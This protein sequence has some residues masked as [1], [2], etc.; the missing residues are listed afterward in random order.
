MSQPSDGVKQRMQQLLQDELMAAA[1]AKLKDPLQAARPC[2]RTEEQQSA[3]VATVNESVQIPD[4]GFARQVAVIAAQALKIPFDRF[5]AQE[6]MSRYGVDSIIVTEIMRHISDLLQTPIAPTVFF[7]ARHTQELAQ[8]LSQRYPAAVA[9]AALPDGLEHAAHEA[10]ET[11]SAVSPASPKDDPDPVGWTQ[12]FFQSWQTING[13][14]PAFSPA[15]TGGGTSVPVAI[16]GMAGQFAQSRDLEAFE[17]NLRQERDCISQVPLDRWDWREVFGDPRQGDYTRV[18]YGGFTPDID[19]FDAQ[20]FGISPREAR[21]MDPQH[22]RYMQCVWQAIESA[23]YAPGSLAGK[24]VGLFIGIN[25]QDYAHLIDREADIEAMHLTSLGHMFCPNRISFLLDLHGPSQVIDTACSSSLVALH[26]AVMSIRHEGCEMAIAGGA[27]LMI[28]SDMHVMYSKVGMICEDGRCKT[29]SDRANGYAR[30]DGVG[31]VVLKRLDLAQRDRDPVLAVI[32]GSAENH[33][34]ASSSL[35]APNPNAQAD[36]IVQAHEDAGVDPR[37]VGYIECHG[38]GTSLG[39]PIEASGLKMALHRLAQRQGLQALPAGQCAIGS[40]KSNIGHAETAAGIAGVIKTV[41]SLQNAYLYRTL[42]CDTLNPMLE[43]SGSPLRVLQ[44]AQVWDQPVIDGTSQPRCAGVS[45]FGAGGS[46]AHVVIQEYNRPRLRHDASMPE[47]MIFSA[48]DR[49]RL[50]TMIDQWRLFLNHTPEQQ[51]PTLSEMAYTM[52]VGRDAMPCR[53]AL[54]IR[55]VKELSQSL[56]AWMNGQALS[57]KAWE[58]NDKGAPCHV[59]STDLENWIN[60]GDWLSLGQAWVTGTAI[61]WNRVKRS[62]NVR[63]AVLPTYPFAPKRH[64]FKSVVPTQPLHPLLHQVRQNDGVWVFTSKFT[65]DAAFLADHRINGVC[66]LPAAAYLEMMRVAWMHRCQA[67]FPEQTG[68]AW[69]LTDVVWVSAMQVPENVPF[70]VELTLAAVT[71]DRFR[72]QVSSQAHGLHCQAYIDRSLKESLSVELPLAVPAGRHWDGQLCYDSFLAMGLQYGASHRRLEQVMTFMRSDREHVLAQLYQ[73]V[74]EYDT[75]VGKLDAGLQSTIGFALS[76]NLKALDERAASLPFSAARIQYHQSLKHARYVWVR[77]T[78]EVNRSSQEGFDIDWFDINGSLCL[79]MRGFISRGLDQHKQSASHGADVLLTEPSWKVAPSVQTTGEPVLESTVPEY[80][81][82]VYGVS[83][84][85]GLVGLDQQAVI[86]RSEDV[87]SDY[88]EIIGAVIAMA[89]RLSKGAEGRGCAVLQV[90]LCAEFETPLLGV[91][92]TLRAISREQTSLITQVILMTDKPPDDVLKSRL[93]GERRRASVDRTVA[94]L[95]G[96]RMV[97]QWQ[98]PVQMVAFH[99]NLPWRI[100]GVYL[101]TGASGALAQKLIAYIREKV[102]DAK[103]GLLSRHRIESSLSDIVELGGDITNVEELARSVHTLVSRCGRVDG[104]I[105]LAGVLKDGSFNTKTSLAIAEVMVPKVAGLVNLD[106][107]TADLNLDFFVTF[108]SLS[109]SFGGAGQSDYAAANA[110]MA[111]FMKARANAVSA[112][113]RHGQS[114]CVDWPFWRDGGMQMPAHVQRQMLRHTGLMPL[115]TD[116]GFSALDALLLG[117]TPHVAVL[118]GQPGEVAE[119]VLQQNE[120]YTLTRAEQYAAGNVELTTENVPSSEELQS[121]LIDLVARMMEYE[122]GDIEIDVDFGDYGFDSISFTELSNTL[123]DELCT[124]VSPTIFF[125]YSTVASLTEWLLTSHQAAA[126]RMIRPLEVISEADALSESANRDQKG[127]DKVSLYPIAETVAE[128]FAEP[129]KQSQT[130]PSPSP[131]PFDSDD[132]PICVVGMSGAFPGARDLQTFWNNL[133]RGVD[134]IGPLPNG[135]WPEGLWQSLLTESDLDR[136]VG[137]YIDDVDLFDARFFKISPTEALSLDPQQRLLM[138]HAVKAL[139]DAGQPLSAL[140]GSSTGVF[141][142]TAPSGYAELLARS[143]KSIDSYSSTGN[144]GSLAANRISYFLNLHGPSEPIETACSS[145]LVAFHRAVTAI[146]CGDCDQA[147]VG[148]ANLLLSPDTQLSFARAHMLSP[149]GRSKAFCADAN[150]YVRGEAVVVLFVKRL[151]RALVDGNPIYGIVAGTAENHGGKAN[152]L[153]APNPA[154]QQAVIAKAYERAGVSIDAV[155]YLEAHGTGTALGDPIEISALKSAFGRLYDSQGKVIR[156]NVCAVGSVKTNIGHTELAAGAAGL[157]KLLLQLKYKR[158]APNLHGQPQ[159]PLIDLTDSPFY[160]PQAAT[161][162]LPPKTASGHPA[163]RIGGV[164]SFGFGGVNAHVVIQEWMT[165][166]E[167]ADRQHQEEPQVVILSARHEDA[168]HRSIESLVAWLDSKVKPRLASTTASIPAQVELRDALADVMALS[169]MD[170]GFEDDLLDIQVRREDRHAWYLQLAQQYCGLSLKAFMDARDIV[171]LQQQLEPLLHPTMTEP[172]SAVSLQTLART[173]QM[174]RDEYDC[175]FAA[176]VSSLDELRRALVS[177]LSSAPGDAWFLSD[178]NSQSGQEISPDVIDQWMNEGKYIEIAK[179]WVSGVTVPWCEYQSGQTFRMCSLPGYPLQ[180]QRFWFELDVSAEP[181]RPPLLASV[182]PTARYPDSMQAPEQVAPNLFEIRLTGEEP[183]LTD[184]M[185]EQSKV[186]PGAAYICFLHSVACTLMPSATS[187]H[188]TA[189]IVIEDL[190]WLRPVVVDHALTVRLRLNR[191]DDGFVNCLFETEQDSAPCLHAKARLKWDELAAAS[192]PTQLVSQIKQTEPLSVDEIYRQFDEAGLHYGNT[193]RSI[194]TLYRHS[195]GVWATI[196]SRMGYQEGLLPGTL[197]AALQTSAALRAGDGGSQ[198][199]LYLPFAID[200]IEITPFMTSSFQCLVQSSA[201]ESSLRK[202]DLLL[203]NQQDVVF[204][205][206]QGFTARLT[207]GQ[208]SEQTSQARVGSL[209][210][211]QSTDQMPSEVAQTR[212][213][214]WF[215]SLVAS[216]LGYEAKDI[217][218]AEDLEAYG[219]DSMSIMQITEKLEASFGPLSKTLFYDFRT[220]SDVIDHFSTHYSD[221]IGHLVID[222][223][224]ARGEA[225]IKA[226]PSASARAGSSA[227]LNVPSTRPKPT[228]DDIA[229]IGVSGRYPRS[230]DLQTFWKNLSDGIDCISEVPPDRWRWQD[231][232]SADRT[233]AGKHFCKWGGFIDEMDCFD[234]LFFNLSPSVGPYLDPQERLFLEYSWQ[235]IEDAGYTRTSLSTVNRAARS[236]AGLTSQIGVYAGVMYGEYQLLAQESSAAGKTSPVGNFY[237]S[238]ANRVSYCL[239]L[240]GPSMALDTMCSSSLTAIH[241]ACQDLRLGVTDMAIAGGVNLNL[242]PNKYGMLSVGQFISGHGRCESFGA[243]GSGYVPGEGVGCVVLKRLADAERDGDNI[244]GIIKASVI[245]HGGKTNGYSVP[246]PMAQRALIRQALE[247]AAV[248]PAAVNYIEAHGTGTKLGDPIEIAGLTGAFADH[249]RSEQPC[250]VGSVKSNIGHGEAAA[251]IASLT[252]VLLQFKHRQLAP[253]LHSEQLNPNIDFAQTPFEVNQILRPWEP[254]KVN[255]SVHSRTAGI[256]SYGAGGSNA[257]LVVQEHRS[258]EL[259]DPDPAWGE[260]PYAFLLSAKDENRLKVYAKRWRTFLRDTGQCVRLL[261]ICYTAQVGREA[262]VERFATIVRTPDELIDH[263]SSFIDDKAVGWCGRCRTNAESSAIVVS[264]DASHWPGQLGAWVQGAVLDWSAVYADES[265]SP[266]RVSVPTYPFA[267]EP[268]RLPTMPPSPATEAHEPEAKADG[269]EHMLV[270]DCL[271]AH[272]H[273]VAVQTSKQQPWHGRRIVISLDQGLDGIATE[274][275]VLQSGASGAARWID[276]SNDLLRRLQALTPDA[277]SDDILFQLVTRPTLAEQS[278]DSKSASALLAFLKCACLERN[279]WRAQWVEVAEALPAADLLKKLQFSASEQQS[280]L[281]FYAG[282]RLAKVWHATT[283][284][285]KAPPIWREGGSYLIVGGAGGIGVVVTRE[286]LACTTAC[287]VVLVGRSDQAQIHVRKALESLRPCVKSTQILEYRSLDATD[288]ASVQ[289]L[290]D[291]LNR[292]PTPGGIGPLNGVIQSVGVLRDSVLARKTETHLREVMTPKLLGAEALIRATQDLDLD[293]VVLFSS[294]AGVTGNHGQADYAAANAYLD[295]LVETPAPVAHGAVKVIDWPLWAEGGMHLPDSMVRGMR[296][297]TGLAPLTTATAMVALYQA[298]HSQ[299]NQVLILP[300]E[301]EKIQQTVLASLTGSQTADQPSTVEDQESAVTAEQLRQHL[302][303]SVARLSDLPEHRVEVDVA[304]NEYGFDSV[305]FMSLTAELEKYLGVGLSQ[306]LFF[307]YPSIST[308]TGYLQQ[309]LSTTQLNAGGHTK[310]AAVSNSSE[311]ADSAAIKDWLCE[312]VANLSQLPLHRVQTDIPLT[313]YG[314][315]SVAFTQLTTMLESRLKRSVSGTLFFEHI[316]IEAAANHLATQVRSVNEQTQTID[317]PNSNENLCQTHANASQASSTLARTPQVTIER[318][319]RAQYTEEIAIVGMAGRFPAAEDVSQFWSNLLRGVDAISEVPPDRWPIEQ[320]YAPEHQL[321]RTYCKWGGFIDDVDCFDPLFFRLSV[322]QAA[323][324]DP[325]ERL[326]LQTVWQ[327]LEQTGY[328][329]ENLARAFEHE[330]GVF[331]GSMYRPYQGLSRDALVDALT[332]SHPQ[333][334]IANRVSQFF[335]FQGPSL[336]ID[337]MCSSALVALQSAWQSLRDDQCKAAIVGGVNLSLDERKYLGLSAGQLL[338]SQP[339]STSFAQGDG[340][341]PAETVGAVLLRPLADALTD[342][343]EVLAIIRGV[344]TVHTGQSNGLFSPNKAAQARMLRTAYRQAGVAPTD[345]DYIESAA[346]GSPQSDALEFRALGEFFGSSAGDAQLPAI[347][348]GAVKSGIGHAE[349]AS[350][351]TQLIKVLLQFRH[352]TLVPTIKTDPLNPAIDFSDSPFMLVNQLQTWQQ[353]P[354][355]D[356]EVQTDR[357]LAAI[358]ALGAG[359]TYAHLILEQ[360]PDRPLLEPDHGGAQLLLLSAKSDVQLRKLGYRVRDELH[361]GQWRLCDVAYTLQVCRVHF[362]ERLAVL[363][364]TLDQAIEYLGQW[365]DEPIVCHGPRVWRNDVAEDTR[366]FKQLVNGENGQAHLER[367]LNQ[368]DLPKLALLWCKG[369]KLTWTALHDRQHRRSLPIAAYPFAKVRCWVDSGKTNVASETTPNASSD[370]GTT[371]LRVSAKQFVV[372]RLAS[373]LGFTPTPGHLS[374]AWVELGVDSIFITTLLREVEPVFAL[375]V[376]NQVMFDL[377][378]PQ[379]LIDYISSRQGGVVARRLQGS[380]GQR[381]LCIL[382]KWQPQSSGYHVPVAMRWP[383]LVEPTRFSR[384]V[385]R[386]IEHHR[387]LG[388]SLDLDEQTGECL[389]FEDRQRRPR[390]EVVTAS[391]SVDERQSKWRDFIDEPFNLASDSLF[392]CQL[393]V[394]QAKLQTDVLLVIHHAVIDGLSAAIVCEDLV[395][396]YDD[397]QHELATSAGYAE[398]IAWQQGFIQSP[399]GLEQKHYWLTRLAVQAPRIVWPKASMNGELKDER[400]GAQLVR[401]VPDEACAA[402]RRAAERWGVNPS[403]LFLSMWYLVVARQ[404]NLT[405]VWLGVP[406]LGRPQTRFSRSVGYFANT[407]VLT[408]VLDPNKTLQGWVKGVAFDLAQALDHADYPYALVHEAVTKAT[409]QA[410]RPLFEVMFAYQNFLPHQTGAQTTPVT[411]IEDASQ[412]GSHPLALEVLPT[413]AGW[414]L[415]IDYQ[416]AKWSEQQI[417]RLMSDCLCLLP[418]FNPDKNLRTICDTYQQLQA[419]TF[420]SVA[421]RFKEAAQN[422]A[423]DIALITSRTTITFGQLDRVSDG[424]AGHLK[425][426]GVGRDDKVALLITHSLDQV[427]ATLACFKLGCAFVPLPTGQPSKRLDL[428]IADA[429]P[430]VILIDDD[431]VLAKLTCTDCQLVNVAQRDWSLSARAFVPEVI[432]PDQVAY[433]IYTSGSTGMPKGVMVSQASIAHHVQVISEVYGLTSTDVALQFAPMHVD[434]AL[435]QWLV[436]LLRGAQVVLRPT[437]VWSVPELREAVKTYRLTVIDLPPSY[438]HEIFLEQ[439]KLAPTDWHQSLRLIISGGESLSPQTARLWAR[440]DLAD[441]SL[442]NAYGPTETTITSLVHWLDASDFVSD[443]A[444]VVPIGV[445]LPGERVYLLD[446]DGQPVDQGAGEITI[447]GTGVAM[448]YHNRPEDNA[449]GF[450]DNPFGQSGRLYRTGDLG[451][452]DAKGRVLYLGRF[453]EQVKI[454]GHRIECPEVASALLRHPAIKQAE[455]IA[456]S[457]HPSAQLV[458]CLVTNESSRPT[459]IDLRM[460]LKQYLPES[461]LPSKFHWFDC[462]PVALSGKVNRQALVRSV[463]SLAQQQLAP[464]TLKTRSV[465]A[466]LRRIW[467]DILQLAEV[468]DDDNFFE[469]GGDSLAAVRLLSQVAEHFHVTWTMS[470]ILENATLSSQVFKLSQGTGPLEMTGPV[471]WDGRHDSIAIWLPPVAGRVGVY[472]PLIRQLGV[473]QTCL[474]MDT[475]PQASSITE[476]AA[477]ML[478]KIG[479]LTGVRQIFLLGWSMGGTIA[480]EMARSLLQRGFDR[481]QLHLMLIDTYRPEQVAQWESALDQA[482]AQDTRYQVNRRAFEQYQ[483]SALDLSV[484][485]IFANSSL[486]LLGIE[487]L[488]SNLVLE[489]CW[490]RAFSPLSNVRVVDTDHDAIITHPSFIHLL[491]DFLS[492]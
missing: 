439:A 492:N 85:E 167:P 80:G 379:A 286:I 119:H 332:A 23:G 194:D 34:G 228:E 105:H 146:K 453:D 470:Q 283:L 29:F 371:Q 130:N 457:R 2:A 263:L 212:T 307:E 124:P 380:A 211:S 411:W 361:S 24:F 113:R 84:A 91:D 385:E 3:A 64:W 244:Q 442:I 359:G 367:L 424:L 118:Y 103:F 131:P 441:I 306:T 25:L 422:A 317:T 241:L 22:R 246:N 248:D 200:R 245:N 356:A 180:P 292:G 35:T 219:I 381:A 210:A 261:D 262:M 1:S 342:G 386:L 354:K 190:I 460:F 473:S 249:G 314:F 431:G 409:G 274:S 221:V 12:A 208:P 108:G 426:I 482:L 311:K 166:E 227:S 16:I 189:C 331:V 401:E 176:V 304:L 156:Q 309:Q 284:D 195:S 40:V 463:E 369:V 397:P 378:T 448:G 384:A 461:M 97:R 421:S 163:P 115:P 19:L 259:P 270:Q 111:G 157:A 38:T 185:V 193:H 389:V 485:A 374:Q 419:C 256:S 423:D 333:S 484:T 172:D 290:V 287:R 59:S 417:N 297:A 87:A 365:L 346:N 427:Y 232:Y 94:W 447:A 435:E 382:Q 14:K 173:L 73:D 390:I 162:W 61:D 345:V 198:D 264:A 10:D 178:E 36:L 413:N 205:K 298:V 6:R 171:S 293:F 174:G 56:E 432:L 455:V 336:A 109:G 207:S 138:T 253:S 267:R 477:W 269:N 338:G 376:T 303:S 255:G 396:L 110:F 353:R 344:A 45:S 489:T 491:N 89:Q 44:Q 469:I 358:N 9:N 160:F 71:A 443:D 145:S 201:I 459:D 129:N 96:E 152:S 199:Q 410:G 302:V 458:A 134:S 364:E 328:L 476:Q 140:S 225:T 235:A 467:Q 295:S 301:V 122:P 67:Q 483:H 112:G 391:L 202:A 399:Q 373:R 357:K 454:N 392:R 230:P 436:P 420:Q 132:D 406:I 139:E 155:G 62:G 305:A 490:P 148:G 179:A 407:V 93:W 272:P 183:F 60:S 117:S 355:S 127:F 323:L 142:G 63:R 452:R 281:R 294:I 318:P 135:R 434:A 327:L 143:G 316:S 451:R 216:V 242:H 330:V 393:Y 196:S 90:L 445:A 206:I 337:T 31:A 5:D 121:W 430:N 363:V 53:L 233:A 403:A 375:T 320:W 243:D 150:G 289:V 128:V 288:A 335:D 106:L 300:G 120:P 187:T 252:K 209:N 204:L 276:Y 258:V 425:D 487:A 310:P 214:N 20:H 352:Q 414:R 471:L 279:G 28:S 285:T 191:M 366:A 158:I 238:I 51:L 468:N 147:L 466:E 268:Y 415:R 465:C 404:L 437:V 21:M 58:S 133:I 348:I 372:A 220:L 273:W 395:K 416:P 360:G 418:L 218:T 136:V 488:D 99:G 291:E 182:S 266:R 70:E 17:I 408:Q 237:A 400:R 33:G 186:L 340:Y 347:A 86:D 72:I 239:D 144:V 481:S 102:P 100:G 405:E 326:F 339:A 429:N 368:P 231:Y 257:H 402:I 83:N 250:Y 312:A 313:Q 54:L 4:A 126:M 377:A 82:V 98:T 240:H 480:I 42:H 75:S 197:D 224:R 149:D 362:E 464:S 66:L 57:G 478:E 282:Q 370:T 428:M 394:E 215:K 265:L 168:L 43:L 95:D 177:S 161:D 137:G 223:D 334:L 92:A 322:D 321:G 438:L 18:K 69:S 48:R 32:R 77:G 277:L 236:Q 319:P 88:S 450:L 203:A 474:G 296:D 154:A 486:D 383:G 351:I 329:G 151:S 308:V 170:V 398:Y 449:S 116:A 412:Q 325:Q 433:M 107:V 341:I 222:E 278:L 456:V 251:G 349:A 153:T 141:L 78:T 444:A 260:R 50:S 39:D 247:K 226:P 271:M 299:P 68:L 387:V 175:R 217:N 47:L 81:L 184:H 8:I 165:P 13:D 125:E 472:Q 74:E 11:V 479:P 27:N 30:G 26:R 46:N 15:A 462:L 164:S 101:I 350:G 475:T 388:W 79:S 65:T 104:V 234:P 229:I 41:L 275:W 55:S 114:L 169:P 181:V 254:P 37:A 315:D 446:S 343:D 440:S 52:Q 49:E 324:I 192:W 76:Q 7:E 213:N 123:G 188:T 280:H 159:N